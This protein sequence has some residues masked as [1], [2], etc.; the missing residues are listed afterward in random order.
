MQ[1]V[2]FRS[3]LTYEWTQVTPTSALRST[4]PRHAAAP[5]SLMGIARPLGKR[6]SIRYRAMLGSLNSSGSIGSDDFSGPWRGIPAHRDRSL[7]WRERSLLIRV[8]I[9][10]YGTTGLLSGADQD[11][12]ARRGPD[13]LTAAAH[14]ELGEDGADVVIDRLLG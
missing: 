2:F 11:A 14:A 1:N 7:D 12:E 4:T 8:A 6:R 5:S 3:S 9:T 10:R 13:R